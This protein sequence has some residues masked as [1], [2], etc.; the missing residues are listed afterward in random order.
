MAI[1]VE[2][3]G[4][5][6]ECVQSARVRLRQIKRE[7]V[8]IEETFVELEGDSGESELEPELEE[9]EL[10]EPEPEEP[11]PEEPEPELEAFD[12]CEDCYLYKE[13]VNRRRKALGFSVKDLIQNTG[14]KQREHYALMAKEKPLSRENYLRYLTGLQLT[15]GRSIVVGKVPKTGAEGRVPFNKSARLLVAKKFGTVASLAEQLGESPDALRR[16]FR[17][18]SDPKES[19]F[20]AICRELGVSPAKLI[21]DRFHGSGR[22]A[23]QRYVGRYAK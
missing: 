22:R 18:E 21:G 4:E 2:K 7:L 3:I 12:D 15:S 9:P 8:E 11:E 13:G 19:L 20:L 10:E 1:S 14:V 23:G 6:V 5:F 16:Y 17:L